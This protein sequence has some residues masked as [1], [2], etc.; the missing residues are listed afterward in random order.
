MVTMRLIKNTHDAVRFYCEACKR[1]RSARWDD[2]TVLQLCCT[3]GGIS[4]MIHRPPPGLMV[5]QDYLG[6]FE[7]Y[8][9][10]RQKQRE[11]DAGTAE[12]KLKEIE[13]LQKEIKMLKAEQ[14]PSAVAEAPEKPRRVTWY[15]DPE[16]QVP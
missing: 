16:G 13:A 1:T 7:A 4:V 5:E 14:G 9:S 6:T 3:C 10:H 15:W 8:Q 11:R 12:M 2:R